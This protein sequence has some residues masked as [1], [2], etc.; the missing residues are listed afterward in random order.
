MK[1]DLCLLLPFK[2]LG[3]PLLLSEL[4]VCLMLRISQK[5]LEHCF[6]VQFSPPCSLL[7]SLAEGLN[8]CT[9]GSATSCEECLLIHP[10]CAWCSKEVSGQTLLVLHTLCNTGRELFPDCSVPEGVGEGSGCSMLSIFWVHVTTQL[11][12][13]TGIKSLTLLAPSHPQ[14][15]ST[16]P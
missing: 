14:Q 4:T 7:F 3:Y 11:F 12:D 8:L 6:A 5:P 15:S 10:K 9:S 16:V 1:R 2:L 13:T